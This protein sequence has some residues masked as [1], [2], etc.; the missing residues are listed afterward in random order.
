MAVLLCAQLSVAQVA[1]VDYMKV[2]E[3]GADAYINLEKQWK[4]FHQTRVKDGK[5]ITWALYYVHNSGSASPYNFITVNI[6]PNLA[7][8]MSNTYSNEDLKRIFGDKYNDVIKKTYASRTL[9]SSGMFNREMFLDNS[10]PFRFLMISFMKAPDMGS[11]LAMEKNAY[12]PAH[13]EAQ[14]AGQLHG[15]SIWTRMFPGDTA[16]NAVAVNS[17]V[18]AEQL[19]GLNYDTALDKLKA[20]NDGNKVFEMFTSFA[21]TE[22]IRS[23]VRTELWEW[24]DGTTPPAAAK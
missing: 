14:A 6:Y 3:G 10:A 20:T 18:S 17:F 19:A 16:Y 1:V 15:W 24:V 8:A 9:T 13:K 11:Y 5:L 21:N 4:T 22:K 7:T 12:M 2:P 23:V